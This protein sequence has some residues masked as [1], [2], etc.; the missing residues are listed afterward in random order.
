MI[1]KYIIGNY[2]NLYKSKLYSYS[3]ITIFIFLLQS[4]CI[5]ILLGKIIKLLTNKNSFSFNSKEIFKD[6]NIKK[7]NLNGYIILFIICWLVIVICGIIKNYIERFIIPRYLGYLRNLLFNSII[8]KY[9]DKYED[10][11]IGDT[12]GKILDISRNMKDCF[13][14]LIVNILPEIVA[15]S[16][17]GITLLFINFRLGI[18]IFI[19]LI[20]YC[21]STIINN[22]KILDTAIK[23]EFNFAIM[24][25]KLSDNFSNLMNIYINNQQENVI[26]ENNN[27]EKDYTKIYQK[28]FMQ[29][30]TL[31]TL[32][33]IILFIIIFVTLIYGIYLLEKKRIN[34][35]SFV[36]FILIITFLTGYCINLTTDLPILFSKLGTIFQ[37]KTFLENLLSS[38]IKKIFNSPQ[39]ENIQGN[40]QFKNVYFKYPE[41]S[42]FILNDLSFTIKKG[43]RLGI[44]GK[45]GSGKTTIMKLI[46][47]MYKLDSGNILIEDQDINLIDADH[48]R[49]NIAYVN[50]RTLMFNDTVINNLKYG[51]NKTDNFIIHFLEKYKLDTLYNKLDD[52]FN[53]MAGVNG[54]NLSLGMQKIIFIC[55]G[56]FRDSNILIFDE[57]LAG[58]DKNTREKVLKMITSECT[59]KTMIVITHDKEIIP[60]MTR[61]IN[62]DELSSFGGLSTIQE[63]NYKF[64]TYNSE[65]E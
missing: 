35:E 40:I 4:I 13:Q 38:N 11:K 16:I 45:S 49:K 29:Q 54:N 52:K 53:S 27:L 25:E 65:L 32:N 55:R 19:L 20:I 34:K 15:V 57:P 17:I 5:P 42:K 28:E 21:I 10:I 7:I 64:K 8:K 26:K 18:I 41:A 51:N 61:I 31:T 14:L 58:L 23:R 3:L 46:L 43:D 48:I 59:S 60:Y 47:K 50:Q 36:T 6:F 9:S 24:N 62:M 63:E 12:L 37:S 39:I 33:S 30:G 2:F 44:L 1:Y 56:I 22:K